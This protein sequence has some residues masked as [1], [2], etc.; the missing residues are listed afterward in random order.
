MCVCYPSDDRGRL[1]QKLRGQQRRVRARVCARVCMNLCVCYPSDE[2]SRLLQRLRGNK[3]VF[4][5]VYE[6]VRV[7]MHVCVCVL[8]IMC[9]V[10]Q[11]M[12][13]TFIKYYKV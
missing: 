9:A 13:D 4:A 8:C 2:K 5:C 12:D 6:C 7:C 3:S 11:L 1:L 10:P